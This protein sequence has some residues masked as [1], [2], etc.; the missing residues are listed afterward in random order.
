MAKVLI[1]DATANSAIEAMRALGVEVV[2]NDTITIEELGQVIGEYDAIVV[3][4]RT[5]VREPILQETGKLKAII[6]GGVGLD[7]IDVDFARGK[8]ILVLNTP[9]ASSNAVAEL[10]LGLMFAL[11]RHITRADASMK[12]GEW[13][14]KALKGTEIEGK[15][16]GIIGYGRIG[17]TLAEKARVLGMQVIAYHPYVKNADIVDFDELLAQSDYISL[18]LPHTEQTHHLIDKA[19]LAKMK[20]GVYLVDAARGGVVDEAAL[21]EALV[22]GHVAGAALDVFSEEPPKSEALQ[23]LIALPQVIASPHIGASTS[24]AQARI[25]D[26]IV[27]LVKEHLT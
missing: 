13:A 16:L 5:K 10:A 15:T 25:G 21:Y 19:A 3:R 1:C 24:E 18:H 7:N 2:V 12:A 8:G 26:E 6:R 11:A 20:P 9:A 27:A 4:S 17:R 22:S 14:K 23:A